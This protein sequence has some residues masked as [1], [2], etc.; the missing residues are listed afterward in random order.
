M[1]FTQTRFWSL[2]KN[3]IIIAVDDDSFV[4]AKIQALRYIVTYLSSCELLARRR[5][6]LF[7]QCHGATRANSGACLSL[8]LSHRMDSSS[9]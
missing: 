3:R 7:I 2:I 9:E 6:Y 5:T 4:R 1:A 8:S